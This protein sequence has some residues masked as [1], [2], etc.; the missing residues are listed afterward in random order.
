MDSCGETHDMRH[1]PQLSEHAIER[2]ERWCERVAKPA[3]SFDWVLQE[4]LLALAACHTRGDPLL[5]VLGPHDTRSG[6]PEYFR[7]QA[8]ELI[9]AV[10]VSTELPRLH[11]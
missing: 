10:R 7:A 6:R 4:M 8:D 2:F 11:R 5:Y 9:C 1:R 3:V